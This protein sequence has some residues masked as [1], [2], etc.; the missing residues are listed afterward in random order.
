MAYSS[1]FDRFVCQ[2]DTIVADV[3]GFTVTAR[4]VYDESTRP[5]D[6]DC[7][8]PHIIDAWRNDDWF[9]CGVCLQVSRAGVD[10]TGPYA[11]ALWGVEANFPCG[12]NP[13]YLTE[14]AVD[15]IP[16]AVAEARAA[17]ARLVAD[18]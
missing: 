11:A 12:D 6:F 17:M 18:A 5:D 9:F 16:E 13:Y 14:I 1:K 15:L 3:D 10:L 2:G 7:Y 8:D 4:I